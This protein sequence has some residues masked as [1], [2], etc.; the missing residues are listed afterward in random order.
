MQLLVLGLATGAASATVTIEGY[1]SAVARAGDV[2]GDGYHDVRVG[3]GLFLGGAGGLSIVPAQILPGYLSAAGDVNADGYGDMI[4]GLPLSG[5][6]EVYLGSASG[7]QLSPATTL[8]GG[9][10]DE[11]FGRSVSGAG[12]V[13]GDGYPDIVVGSVGGE[14]ALAPP[15]STA[16]PRPATAPRCWAPGSGRPRTRSSAP[17][18]RARAT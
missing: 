4:V 12:D 15:T 3:E 16:A 6:V 13:N 2:N 18:S 7:L 10:A 9:A 5:Q 17:R 14:G 1:G 8:E 11:G